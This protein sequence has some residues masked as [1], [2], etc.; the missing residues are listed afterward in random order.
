MA[1]NV[2]VGD[3]KSTTAPAAT[4]GAASPQAGAEPDPLDELP[5]AQSAT[6][7]AR[8]RDTFVASKTS[9]TKAAALSPTLRPAAA[10]PAKRLSAAAPTDK[11]GFPAMIRL[12]TST[13]SFNRKYYFLLHDGRIYVKPNREVTGVDGPWTLAGKDGLPYEGRGKPASGAA[14]GV[15]E[16]SVDGA[17]LVAILESGRLCRITNA[18][19]EPEAF[20]WDFKW[21]APLGFGAGISLPQNAKAWATS[22]DSPKE[23]KF[24]VDADG[25]KHVC[26]VGTVYALLDDNRI[27]YADAWTPNDWGRWITLPHVR[28]ADGKHQELVADA[29][30]ACSSSVALMDTHGNIFTGQQD[31]DINDADNPFINGEYAPHDSFEG[32]ALIRPRRLPAIPWQQET[33]VTDE[34]GRPAKITR[35]LSILLETDE[36]GATVPGSAARLLRVAGLGTDPATGTEVAGYWQ[37]KMNFADPRVPAVKRAIEEVIAAGDNILSPEQNPRPEQKW[38]FVP[39]PEMDIATLRPRLIDNTDKALVLKKSQDFDGAGSFTAGSHA[40]PLAAQLKEFNLYR[41]PAS[42]DIDLGQ[43]KH[44]SLRLDTRLPYR[45]EKRE[46]PGRDGEPAKLVGVLEVPAECLH[47]TDPDVRRFVDKVFG[48]KAYVNVDVLAT[49]QRVEVSKGF[50]LVFARTP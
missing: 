38:L 41:S 25:N 32:V 33:K 9:S 4:S 37:K 27:V 17:S 18:L 26:Y 47:S 11:A 43:G 5:V 48:G 6:D 49:E 44:I 19:A 31:Y 40:A 16:I 14:D 24:Y 28:A 45:D 39:C 8:S 12:H 30:D 46:D 13:Q 23:N 15:K 36:H 1:L 20:K 34:Q 35:Q 42:I 22:S 7:A 10:E 21:G 3:V 50:R 2:K 29:M